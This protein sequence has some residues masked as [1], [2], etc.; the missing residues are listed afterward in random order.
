MP[1]TAA[2]MQF[3][4]SYSWTGLSAG[5][6]PYYQGGVSE[7]QFDRGNGEEVLLFINHFGAKYWPATPPSLRAYHKI[8]KMLRKQ[9]PAGPVTHIEA[10]RFLIT[11][12]LKVY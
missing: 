6:A 10:E 8:E 11:N 7:L 2:N 12:W 5:E 9:L 3:S 1:Y 4:D